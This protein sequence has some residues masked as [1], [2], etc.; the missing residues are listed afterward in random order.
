MIPEGHRFTAKSLRVFEGIADLGEKDWRENADSVIPRSTLSGP[1]YAPQHRWVFC[2]DQRPDEAWLFR[3][4]DER[5]RIPSKMCFHNSFRDP[6]HLQEE[7]SDDA[8]PGRR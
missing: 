1:T 7:S 6:F 5:E 8:K 3:Q 2:S 4:Y